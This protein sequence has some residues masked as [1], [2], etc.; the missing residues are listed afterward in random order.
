[1]GIAE[2]IAHAKKT[3]WIA[4]GL[5]EAEIKNTVALAKISGHIERCR[6]DMHMS[7]K[8]FA[9]YMGVSQSM[10][11]KWE[12]REYNFTTKALNEICKKLNLTI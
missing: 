5:S 7:Q 3:D 12:S 6:I 4:E 1:M 2:K 11:S 9:T 8:E 10:I